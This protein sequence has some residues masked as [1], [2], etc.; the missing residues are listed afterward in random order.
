MTNPY[1]MVGIRKCFETRP[2]RCHGLR[3]F[4]EYIPTMASLSNGLQRVRSWKCQA[5]CRKG[6]CSGQDGQSTSLSG[7]FV[8]NEFH[9]ALCSLVT[10]FETC[11]PLVTP[12]LFSI[13][14]VEN[15]SECRK[16][17]PNSA[18]AASVKKGTRGSMVMLATVCTGSA[19]GGRRHPI[20]A[21]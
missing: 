5:L 11:L 4:S 18:A 15:S 21:I 8:S 13:Q 2:L 17:C 7:N 6:R 1:S 20:E 12:S 14:Y 9:T 10:S 16:L 19:K 3:G